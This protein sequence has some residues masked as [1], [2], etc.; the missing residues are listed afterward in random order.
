VK[1]K[2][3]YPF[4]IV[5]AQF[6]AVA[7]WLSITVI[8]WVNNPKGSPGIQIP[9]IVRSIEAIAI[10]MVSGAFILI[11]E[12]I[13]RDY[14]N[15]YIR[16]ALWFLI[17]VGA[18]ISNIISIF[19]RKL[20]GYAPPKIEGYFFIQS[21]H[22]YIPILLVIIIYSL[23]KNRIEVQ[24]ER[25]NKLKAESFAQQAKWMMLRYQVNP[26]FLFNA[27]NTI[28]ALIG[29]DDESARKIVTE[30][31]EYFRYSLSS[32]EK[33]MVSIEEEINAVNN[34]LEIQKIRFQNKIN[35]SI[36]ISESTK[37]CLI[38]VFSIQTLVENAIK[39]GFKTTDKILFL[40]IES[41]GN[42][43]EIEI[44]VKN[45]GHLY[46]ADERS[47]EGTSKGLNNLKNRLDHLYPNQNRFR[48]IENEGFVI[49]EIILKNCDKYENMESDNS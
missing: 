12:N 49:A 34:Y 39:Y 46:V 43:E 26:H 6:I 3:I 9:L 40:D 29:S 21:L 25:E 15:N 37:H 4:Q 41:K 16:L 27:L 36:N 24:V 42:K 1:K 33:Y 17:Y 35:I 44:L 20:L 19:L 2:K 11:F 28:R 8:Q 10:L 5:I 18:I 38:P 32:E 13:K 31:S 23:G 47:N 7:I 30:M 22:F 48:L 14:K 45:S